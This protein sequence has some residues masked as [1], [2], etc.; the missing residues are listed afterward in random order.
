MR[1]PESHL[2]P[3]EEADLSFL[4]RLYASTRA[5]EMALSGWDQPAIDAFLAQ[6]FDAQHHY[7]QEHYQGSDFSLICHGEQAI[8]RLYI[9][10]GPTTINLIDISL[11]PEWRGKG[12]G[13]RYLAALVDE[14]DAAEK[15]IR[16]FVEPTNPAKRLYE[17]FA[18]RISGSNH[19]YLQMHREAVPALAVPA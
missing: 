5:Q 15:S 19:I 10:R 1:S 4:H 9:F 11:L 7:Y 3:A 18:F 8:G 12:I 13:T 16:L 17:R 14:A 6:Q 2:R